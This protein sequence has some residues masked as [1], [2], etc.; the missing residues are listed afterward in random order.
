MHCIQFRPSPR[1]FQRPSPGP[2]DEINESEQHASSVH[3][4]PISGGHAAASRGGA[5]SFHTKEDRVAHAEASRSIMV[6]VVIPRE[7]VG[8]IV[9][10]DPSAILP[11][12]LYPAF[13]QGPTTRHA[14]TTRHET[15]NSG[16]GE[17][18]DMEL[19]LS[20]PCATNVSQ[21]VSTIFDVWMELR[22]KT[23]KPT[24][25]HEH[26]LYRK[27]VECGTAGIMLPPGL[28]S[29][30][31]EVRCLALLQM[32]L[33]LAICDAAGHVIQPLKRLYTP[34][35]G[36]AT[37]AVDPIK[38]V[39]SNPQVAHVA[40]NM[41]VQLCHANGMVPSQKSLLNILSSFVPPSQNA[42]PAPGSELSLRKTARSGSPV[43]VAAAVTE[44]AFQPPFFLKLVVPSERKAFRRL[45]LQETIFRERI[46]AQ[47]FAFLVNFAAPYYTEILSSDVA[48]RIDW[49]L[50][51]SHCRHRLHIA[52]REA[53]LQSEH[54]VIFNQETRERDVCLAEE[55][56]ECHHL[57]GQT[58]ERLLLV[59]CAES[60]RQAMVVS[61]EASCWAELCFL[62]EHETR[63]MCCLLQSKQRV[64]YFLEID[65]FRIE[66]EFRLQMLREYHQATKLLQ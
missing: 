15:R 23:G 50:Y 62:F 30:S 58:F 35:P 11:D 34:K 43:V 5:W 38:I 64:E 33:T 27:I 44:A 39:A 37:P 32:D 26:S 19:V 18:D 17:S 28:E 66:E 21:A 31:S 9:G 16:G 63:N 41:Q 25:L 65:G 60:S 53:R 40:Q 47:S 24:Q 49:I 29:I 1:F 14:S 6:T 2:H 57:I 12:V 4:S 3:P 54:G 10:G 56:L 45:Q 48:L 7:I 55:E 36:V 51:Q 22:S 42:S 61:K 46:F 8:H 52:E 13:E 59:A 20:L